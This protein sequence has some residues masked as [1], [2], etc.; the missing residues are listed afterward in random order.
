M[1]DFI[2]YIRNLNRFRRDY[3]GW[4]ITRSLSSILDELARDV[5]A[6]ASS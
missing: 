4:R 3:P 1:G 5:H 6:A 2:C